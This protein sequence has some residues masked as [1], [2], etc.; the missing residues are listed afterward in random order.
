MITATLAI[1][2]AGNMGKSLLTGLIADGYPVDKLWITDQDSKTLQA[3]QAE[4]NVHVTSHNADAARAAS[5]IILAVKP[6]AILSV[7]QE[8]APVIKM[9][10]PLVIS[11]AAG[12]LE[13]S[14]EQSLGGQVAVVRCM[15][16]TPAQIRCGMTALHANANVSAMQRLQA[17]AIMQA[18]GKIIW[19]DDEKQMNAVTALSGSGPAY[20]FLFI[21]ALAD[22]G[23]ALGLPIDVARLLAIE[24]AYGAIQMAKTSDQSLAD[25]RKQVTSKGGT[26]EQALRVL[27]EKDLR[28][29]LQAALVAANQ[30]SEELAEL[31]KKEMGVSK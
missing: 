12:V 22:A 24:T 11:I 20:F 28:G 5:I 8:L 31:L 29:M 16:N 27:E 18:I 13:N 17:G 6:Q 10:Q 1:I 23:H 14:I 25:L 26:T 15:P 3:L 19:L 30:R 7:M 21:D 2:G 4:W 9:T